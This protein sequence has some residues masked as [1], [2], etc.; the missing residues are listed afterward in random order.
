MLV[1]VRTSSLCHF[2]PFAPLLIRVPKR[3]SDS[4]ADGYG[5]GFDLVVRILLR[6]LGTGTV[7]LDR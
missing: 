4:E 5:Y 6:L 2:Q 7:L 1:L 3:H